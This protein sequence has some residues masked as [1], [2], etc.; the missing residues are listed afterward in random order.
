MEM[1]AQAAENPPV[2]NRINLVPNGPETTDA[3]L[4]ENPAAAP[5]SEAFP[6]EI[7]PPTREET[8]HG[9]FHAWLC[10]RIEE[11]QNKQLSPWQKCLRWLRGEPSRRL[12]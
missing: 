12:L 1:A 7:P 6:A 2:V 3:G 11:V 4:F 5:A 8:S 9:E 10:S